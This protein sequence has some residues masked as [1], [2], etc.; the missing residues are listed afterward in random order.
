MIDRPE[1]YLHE[2]ME[3]VLRDHENRPMSPVELADEINAQ[4]LYWQRNG[5]DVPPGQI[6]AR[7]HNYS[8][9]FTRVSG[10]IRLRVDRA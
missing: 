2:A 1:L 10:R 6:G 8:N 5:G 7:A 9:R 4:R 3:K